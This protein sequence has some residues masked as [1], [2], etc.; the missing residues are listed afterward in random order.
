MNFKYSWMIGLLAG[1]IVTIISCATV[2]S[3]VSTQTSPSNSTVSTSTAPVETM[4]NDVSIDDVIKEVSDYLNGKLQPGIKVLFLNLKSDYPDLST[5]IIDGLIINATNDGVFIPVDRDNL[6]AIQ[7]EMDFQLSGEV[8]DESAQAIG[9]KLGAQSIVSGS[10][11]DF[12]GDYLLVVRAIGVEDAAI[13]GQFR[14]DLPQ[15]ARL[16]ALTRSKSI[17]NEIMP[18]NEPGANNSSS[19]NTNNTSNSST[20]TAIIQEPSDNNTALALTAATINNPTDMVNF[21]QT[22]CAGGT[23]DKLKTL[24]L[25][26]N[27]TSAQLAKVIAE[28]VTIDSFIELDLTDVTGITAVTIGDCLDEN[29]DRGKTYVLSL[30]LPKSLTEIEGGGSRGTNQAWSGSPAFINCNSL[31]KIIIPNGVSSIGHKAFANCS[32]LRSI[33]IPNG[34]TFIGNYAFANCKNLASVSIGFGV[35]EI[36]D[37]A[38]WDCVT[39]NTVIIGGNVATIGGNWASTVFPG[40]FI[41]SY[42]AGGSG[43]YVRDGNSWTKQ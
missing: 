14:K 28:L 4:A 26:G 27:I 38:F 11:M 35:S 12:D 30:L 31:L 21:M 15:G 36:Q 8:S 10:I 29:N 9:K 34:V 16:T 32:N 2:A 20:P 5:Y 33:S 37:Y 19:T 23:P 40:N 25:S 3:P 22:N 42:R 18:D 7:K 39:L 6:A 24:K 13:Q 1:C 41:S 17:S 43:T